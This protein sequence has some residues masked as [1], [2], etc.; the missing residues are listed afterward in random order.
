MNF[1]FV[2]RENNSQRSIDDKSSQQEIFW[3][4]YLKSYHP[5][6]LYPGGIR[7]HGPKLKTPPR[8]AD[9]TNSV[10]K[11]TTIQKYRA[12]VMIA[13]FTIFQ[14]C[15]LLFRFKIGITLQHN[16]RNKEYHNID[17]GPYDNLVENDKID[18][19]AWP[20]HWLE[21]Q[22][23]RR[24]GR[25]PRAR[26]TLPS[27]AGSA[28]PR[29]LWRRGPGVNSMNQFRP[30]FTG[31]KLT[32]GLILMWLFGAIKSKNFASIDQIHFVYS[33]WMKCCP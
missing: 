2:T 31:K 15:L 22:S 16:R 23:V 32:Q 27:P 11:T 19:K 25:C 3:C 29:P 33:F 12:A 21:R 17:P 8:Q 5:S 1:K 26:P 13:A 24:R 28:G 4:F 10:N 6:Y 7:S 18:F 20:H 30:E 9:D 14:D